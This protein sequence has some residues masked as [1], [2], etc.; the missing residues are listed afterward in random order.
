MT[1]DTEC[2]EGKSEACVDFGIF[3]QMLFTMLSLLDLFLLGV[4]RLEI[5]ECML[6]SPDSCP[7]SF[8]NNWFHQAFTFKNTHNAV[9]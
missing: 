2:C 7:L 5:I 9:I 6:F 1:V 3:I 8:Y 4:W